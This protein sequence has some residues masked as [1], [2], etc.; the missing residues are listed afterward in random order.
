SS[1]Y[2]ARNAASLASGA[3]A[4]TSEGPLQ[5]AAI[6]AAER[7]DRKHARICWPSER[8]SEPATYAAEDQVAAVIRTSREL[9][10]RV[11][12]LECADQFDLGQHMPAHRC[13]QRR[14]VQRLARRNQVIECIEFVEITMPPDRRTRS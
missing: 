6:T 5:I 13:L 11:A 10:L 8:K 7:S 9:R 3:C 4:R 12:F 2:N 14:L 1:W